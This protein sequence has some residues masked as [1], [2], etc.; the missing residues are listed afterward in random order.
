MTFF[1]KISHFLY[2]HHVSVL[3][4]IFEFTNYILCGN[5]ISAK[6]KIDKSSKFWHRGVGCVVHFNAIIGK[7]C[8]IFP[9]VVIGDAFKRGQSNGKA[10]KI[11]NSVFIGAGAVIVGDITIGDGAII[12][13]NAVVIKDVKPGTRVV[14]IPAKEI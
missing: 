14:G 5:A 3:A 7:N 10:P 1:W 6:A 11:G 13:A 8:K 4:R 9:N 2:I 12:G